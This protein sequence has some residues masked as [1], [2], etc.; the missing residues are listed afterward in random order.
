[1]TGSNLL[2]IQL[3]QTYYHA[4]VLRVCADDNAYQRVGRSD[5]KAVYQ[6]IA[7]KQTV[8]EV[9]TELTREYRYAIIDIPS[10]SN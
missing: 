5:L 2:T 7:R 10:R 8:F 1:M 4:G 6:F 3:L 9:G